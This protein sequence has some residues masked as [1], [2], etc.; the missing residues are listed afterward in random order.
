ML[1][2]VELQGKVE[3]V[4]NLEMCSDSWQILTELHLQLFWHDKLV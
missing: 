3:A 2:E 1:K 4:K